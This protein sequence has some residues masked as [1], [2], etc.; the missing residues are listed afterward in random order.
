MKSWKTTIAGVGA[1]LTAVGHALSALFD[2]DPSTVVQLDVTVGAILAGVGL[3]AARDN[4]VTSEQA[5]VK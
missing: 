1:I 3:I 5:G 4:G 2:N